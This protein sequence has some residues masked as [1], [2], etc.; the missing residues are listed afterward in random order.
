[1]ERRAETLKILEQ[2][3]SDAKAFVA[4]VGGTLNVAGIEVL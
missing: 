3:W 2:P 1:M 4:R